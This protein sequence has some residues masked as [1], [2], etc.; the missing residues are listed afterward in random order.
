MWCVDAVV[1]CIENLSRMVKDEIV[2]WT[3]CH[4]ERDVE[5]KIRKYKP[6]WPLLPKLLTVGRGCFF[7]F[8]DEQAAVWV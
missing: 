3:N 4:R 7:V 2:M 5:Y 6:V 1:K 8:A